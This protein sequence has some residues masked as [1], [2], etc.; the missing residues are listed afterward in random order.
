MTWRPL[1]ALSGHFFL[2]REYPLSGVKRTSPRRVPMS[3]NEPKRTLTADA[4]RVSG[5]VGP[6]SNSK[7]CVYSRKVRALGETT[8]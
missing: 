8:C 4:T 1:L 2:H 7:Q 5:G 6:W 3:A